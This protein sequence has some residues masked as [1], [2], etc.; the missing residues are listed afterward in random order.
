MNQYN[1]LKTH[2]NWIDCRKDK[3]RVAEIFIMPIL[4]TDEPTCGI[5]EIIIK[6]KIYMKR[7]KSWRFN[8]LVFLIAVGL[9]K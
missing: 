8:M 9:L 2:E 5:I 4:V 7:F 3:L 1:R 6:K